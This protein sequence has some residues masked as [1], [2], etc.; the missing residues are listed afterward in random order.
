MGGH[1]PHVDVTPEPRASLFNPIL[2]AE[3][4]KTLPPGTPGQKQ[5]TEPINDHRRAC[6]PR[7]SSSV[8]PRRDIVDILSAVRLASAVNCGSGH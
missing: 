8:A 2:G 3:Q 5:P 1:A 6:Q 7:T 4:G